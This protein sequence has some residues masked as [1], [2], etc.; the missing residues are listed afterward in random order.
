MRL[1]DQLPFT[2]SDTRSAQA[3]YIIMVTGAS[4]WP[5]L[6]SDFD[7]KTCASFEQSLER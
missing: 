1:P 6:P 2:V 7:K 4:N 3:S 5:M